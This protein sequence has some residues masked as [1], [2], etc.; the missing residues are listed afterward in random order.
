M[1]KNHSLVQFNSSP[2]TSPQWAS[3]LYHLGSRV[4]SSCLSIFHDKKNSLCP[5][6]VGLVVGGLNYKTLIGRHKD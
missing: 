5:G 3:S 4:S 1:A 2:A 6:E